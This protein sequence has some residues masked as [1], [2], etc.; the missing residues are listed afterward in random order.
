MP[1]FVKI[2]VEGMEFEVIQ[3]ILASVL[4][5]KIKYVFV[6]LSGSISKKDKTI[7]LLIDSGFKQT[8]RRN[9]GIDD[10]LFENIN[11][12]LLSQPYSV[13]EHQI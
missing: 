9:S 8:F 7:K 3:E 10:A 11:F 5:K 1:V 6:E 12:S 4:V 2:D 13:E